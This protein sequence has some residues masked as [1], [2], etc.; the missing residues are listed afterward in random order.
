MSDIPTVTASVEPA[1]PDTKPPC[2]S[3]TPESHA[4]SW[5]FWS[6]TC[7]KWLHQIIGYGSRADAIKAV[8]RCH[9][10]GNCGIRIITIPGG[11][12]P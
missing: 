2:P 7:N 6:E 3:V 11:P 10:D 5:W 9:K 8:E 1:P 4:V 12:T